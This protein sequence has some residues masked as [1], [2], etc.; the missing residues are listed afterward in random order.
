[1]LNGVGY[2]VQTYHRALFCVYVHTLVINKSYSNNNLQG[3]NNLSQITDEHMKPHPMRNSQA[4]ISKSMSNDGMKR[5]I[6][7]PSIHQY[8]NNQHSK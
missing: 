7:L 5:M 4:K 8:V 3:M 1:M 6:R 2:Q